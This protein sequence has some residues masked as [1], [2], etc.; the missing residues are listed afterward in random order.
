MTSMVRER[1][2]YAYT[3]L[4]ELTPQLRRRIERTIAALVDLLDQ[5]DAA[6]ENLEEGGDDEPSLGWTLT[7]AHGWD[8]PDGEAEAGCD[9]GLGD[10]GG[11]L[12]QGYWQDAFGQGVA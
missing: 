2:L 9:N 6:H 3:D 5:V 12:E 8:G 10:A 7:M 4:I 1:D 11:A